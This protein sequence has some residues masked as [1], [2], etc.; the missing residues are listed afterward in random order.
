MMSFEACAELL[1]TKEKASTATNNQAQEIHDAASS[2]TSEVAGTESMKASKS[3]KYSQ[4][5]STIAGGKPH[6][7]R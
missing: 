6:N 5:P 7:H 2:N 3:P 4:L 1:P